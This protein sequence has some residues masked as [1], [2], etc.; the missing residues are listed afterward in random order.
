[1][2]LSIQQ[3]W[4]AA[5]FAPSAYSIQSNLCNGAGIKSFCIAG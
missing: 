5:F 4:Q 2:L 1:M 3:I